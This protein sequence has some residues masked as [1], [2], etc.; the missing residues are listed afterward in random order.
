MPN[1]VKLLS[2]QTNCAL[3][4]YPDEDILELSFREIV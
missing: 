2:P 3:S 4:I 1:E